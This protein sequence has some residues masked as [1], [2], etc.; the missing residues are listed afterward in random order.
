[1]TAVSKFALEILTI[2]ILLFSSCH[3]PNQV[4]Y[5]APP[6]RTMPLN[7]AA[8]EGGAGSAVWKEPP[9][10][11][12][13]SFT[14]P[15]DSSCPVRIGL[16]NSGRSLVRILVDSLYSPGNHTIR[17]LV[18]DSQGKA[19]PLGIYYYQFEICGK[20]STLKFPYR[21]EKQ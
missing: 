18:R 3:N 1:M 20:I 21:R 17:W 11:A 8:A 19:L 6:P 9:D 10:S 14:V 5:T 15:G 2:V 4:T 16:H 12:T 7:S 13:V